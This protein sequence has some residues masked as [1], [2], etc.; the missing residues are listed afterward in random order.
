MWGASDMKWVI[1]PA[2]AERL[3]PL[4]G[5]ESVM[6][7][8][9]SDPSVTTLDTEYQP[10]FEKY[11][12][13]SFS[14]PLVRLSGFYELRYVLGAAFFVAMALLTLA[15]PPKDENRLGFV[16]GGFFGIVLFEWVLVTSLPPTGY[17]TMLDQY[18][19]VTLVV[20]FVVYFYNSV[21]TLNT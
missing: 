2:A 6:G 7:S 21:R 20:V 18:V 12:R 9:I 3:I 5:S 14:I 1:P 11:N 17:D 15:V 16:Q 4:S 13:A 10:F 19:N 8:R